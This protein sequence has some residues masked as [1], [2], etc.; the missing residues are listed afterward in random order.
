[1]TIA[2]SHWANQV[3][4]P[5][6]LHDMSVFTKL[7]HRAFVA[8]Q[9]LADDVGWA[10]DEGIGTIINNRPDGESYDQ[11]AGRDIERAAAA[12]GMAYHFI[13]MH[14]G[15]THETEIE[16]TAAIL[17]DA[18]KPVLLFCRSGTRSAMLW[19]MA[20]VRN[21][22]DADTVIAAVDKAGFNARLV[23]GRISQLATG[24]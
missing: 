10:A 5:E 20:S 4:L 7:G 13:P 3:T 16:R 19:A 9:I 6:E 12:Q 23:A 2:Q 14:M 8:G 18:N 15:E 21:G 17:Q 24:R 22:A 11:P 1:M